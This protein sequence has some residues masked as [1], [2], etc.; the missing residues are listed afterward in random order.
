MGN[1]V[2]HVRGH[3]QFSFSEAFLAVRMLSDESVAKFLPPVCVSAGVGVSRVFEPA[4]FSRLLG[5]GLCLLVAFLS[6]FKMSG[7][8]PLATRHW[9][10]ASGESA[11]S[12]QRHDVWWPRRR[13]KIDESR[14]EAAVKKAPQTRS[15]S[16]RLGRKVN[17]L[18]KRKSSDG[19]AIR[20]SFEVWRTVPLLV[21][22]GVTFLAGATKVAFA[23]STRT[24]THVG[25]DFPDAF[26]FW[27]RSQ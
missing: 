27:S 26:P 15:N 11:E 24:L 3:H 5:S 12:H 25:P 8:E 7:A 16:R 9:A 6:L 19:A 13:R 10:P 22:S 21:P 17:R 20:L 23:T 4:P 1:D 2:V 18:H 14:R